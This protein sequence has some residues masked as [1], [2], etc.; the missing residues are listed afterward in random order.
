MTALTISR[1]YILI[2][3][4]DLAGKTSICKELMGALEGRLD[5]R[6]NKLSAGNMLF[7]IAD[8]FRFTRGL[9]AESLGHLY[10]AAAALD[11]KLY[12]KP[13]RLAVQDST[14]ALRSFA[15]YSARGMDLLASSFQRLLDR[16][17]EFDLSIVLTANIAVRRE[18]LELRRLAT[19]D[20]IADDDELV[21][22]EPDTFR[23]MED[24]LIEEAAA[25]FNAV[26]LDTSELT[27]EQ[28]VAAVLKMMQMPSAVTA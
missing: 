25:R 21:N 13:R 22:R 14:I 10:L 8:R 17:P 4:L 18:R 28:A 23:R 2:E 11:L 3:G 16:Y 26:L 12:E 24:A 6:R 15:F 19:P 20:E 27:L 5:Y 9:D 1:P 7:D